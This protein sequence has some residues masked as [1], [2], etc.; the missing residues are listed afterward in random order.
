MPRLI[1][2]GRGDRV[3]VA[4]KDHP[5]G[6]A[7]LGAGDHV[8]ADPLDREPRA[9]AQG[10]LH[11]V[12]HRPFVVTHRGDRDQRG[13]QLEQAASRNVAHTETPC[14]RSTSFNCALS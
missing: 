9:E 2:G 14:W 13:G 6:L 5:C 10:R 4:R 12:G 7:E 11:R 8:V 3:Q 1:V